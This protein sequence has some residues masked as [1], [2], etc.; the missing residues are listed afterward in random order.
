MYWLFYF[1]TLAAGIGVIAISFWNEHGSWTDTYHSDLR[2][3]GLWIVA[4]VVLSFAWPFLY[5]AILIVWLH[6]A[7]NNKFELPP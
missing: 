4:A 5:V 6:K 7:K 3:S 1:I 2:R